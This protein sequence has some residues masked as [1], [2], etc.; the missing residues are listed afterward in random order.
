MGDL[1][2]GAERMPGSDPSPAGQNSTLPPDCLAPLKTEC[3][4]SHADKK[5]EPGAEFPY[6]P[7]F[8]A[9]PFPGTDRP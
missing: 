1:S 7:K 3:I 6:L 8:L 4:T 9:Q 5:Q 2:G